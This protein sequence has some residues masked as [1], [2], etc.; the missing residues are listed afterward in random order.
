M[1]VTSIL[2]FSYNVLY[3]IKERNVH[4]SNKQQRCQFDSAPQVLAYLST[5][6]SRGAFRIALC[7]SSVVHHGSTT[8]SLNINSSQTTG[9]IQTKLGR[10]VPWVVCFKKYF[11]NMIPSQTLVAMATKWNFLRNT[12]KIFSDETAGPILK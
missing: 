1:L 6:C 4:F 7:P 2:S 8:I 10:N 3:L 9:P 12:L 5:T 11:Q